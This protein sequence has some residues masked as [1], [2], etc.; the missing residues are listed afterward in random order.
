MKI[1]MNDDEIDE[2][3]NMIWMVLIAGGGKTR[4]LDAMAVIGLV[5]ENIHTH[6]KM[7]RDDSEKVF[8]EVLTAIK[9]D[10]LENSW[11]RN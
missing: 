8:Q 6:S 10:N 9:L 1:K 2:M 5:V 3:A 11:D 4:F 7:D